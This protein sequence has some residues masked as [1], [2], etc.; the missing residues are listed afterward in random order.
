MS[1]LDWPRRGLSLEPP[2]SPLCVECD[3]SGNAYCTVYVDWKDG[4]SHVVPDGGFMITCPRCDGDGAE[5]EPDPRDDPALDD[6]VKERR[7]GGGL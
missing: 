7:Y 4:V 6:R 1:A 2:E 3:G 5:P